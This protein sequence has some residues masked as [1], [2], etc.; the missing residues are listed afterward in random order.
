MVLFDAVIYVAPCLLLILLSLKLC[1]IAIEKSILRLSS[2]ISRLLC[3]YCLPRA[4]CNQ[5]HTSTLAYDLQDIQRLYIFI[6]TDPCD[7]SPN[8]IFA[9]ITIKDSYNTMKGTL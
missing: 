4:L 3:T 8:K 9:R 7:R 2:R 1:S 5:T 6:K